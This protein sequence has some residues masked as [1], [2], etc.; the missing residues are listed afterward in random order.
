VPFLV[1]SL[2]LR[3]GGGDYHYTL[4]ALGSVANLVDGNEAV[5]NDYLYEAFSSPHGTPT[6]NVTNRLRFTGREGWA[7]YPRYFRRNW[8]V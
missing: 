6:Q 3:A 4:D 1:D 2:V 8:T 7:I 5:Q